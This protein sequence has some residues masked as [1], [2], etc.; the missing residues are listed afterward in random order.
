MDNPGEPDL[1]N[2]KKQNDRETIETKYLSAR[3]MWEPRF[4]K[5]ATYKQRVVKSRHA[6]AV[7]GHRNTPRAIR[8]KACVPLSLNQFAEP[9]RGGLHA[10]GWEA[11]SYRV[12]A[13]LTMTTNAT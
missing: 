10:Q 9:R 11:C 1:G 3:T 13:T 5:N 2:Q 8:H 12:S 6:A 4:Q 7:E